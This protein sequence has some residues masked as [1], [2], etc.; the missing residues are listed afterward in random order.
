MNQKLI[1]TYYLKDIFSLDISWLKEKSIKT[2]FIDL[3]NT[4]A[5]PYVAYPDKKVMDFIFSLKDFSL[6][7]LSNNHEERVK[8]FTK[9]L[10][11]QY[12]YEVKKPN[13]KK[14]LQYI[15]ENHLQKENCIAIGDQIMTDVYCANR[16]GIPVILVDPLTKQD[17]PITFFPRL[18]DRFFRKKI[19]RKKLT[20]EL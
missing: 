15:A 18:L 14:V 17:E 16:V 11:V 12:L 2:I 5:N 8:T 3:D 19:Q 10:P 9:N 1:P 7:I 4:L 20:K 13:P 6:V